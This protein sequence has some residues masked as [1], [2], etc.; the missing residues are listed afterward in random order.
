[1]EGPKAIVKNVIL[2]PS[3]VVQMWV[4]LKV[5]LTP[6]GDFCEVSVTA[7]FF[8]F[9]FVFFLQISLCTALSDT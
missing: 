9:F 1:M 3:A 4:W 7:F 2:D 6:K 5:K 8:V